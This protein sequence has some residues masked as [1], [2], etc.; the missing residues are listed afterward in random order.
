[1][2]QISFALALIAIVYGAKLLAQSHKES[3]S[4][5]YKYLAWFVMAMGFLILLC[6]GAQ[7]LMRCCHRGGGRM[8]R[9]E[10]MM[11]NGDCNDP[12]MMGG[13][14]MCHRMMM[15]HCNM[16]G[17]MS[18]G[19]DP[20]CKMMM[21]QCN[22][23]NNCCDGGMMNCCGGNHCSDGMMNC[24]DGDMSSCKGGMPANCPMMKGGGEKVKDSLLD[25]AKSNMKAEKKK[26]DKE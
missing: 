11:M 22:G 17:N 9:Q 21:N 10:C 1:M 15:N 24:K 16:G 18:C 3:L 20:C 7:G 4:A 26:K 19:N 25:A 23:N 13:G 14:P 2:I 8:M 12:G 5:M 6:D